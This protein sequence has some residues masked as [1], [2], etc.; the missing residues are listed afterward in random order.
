[1]SDKKLVTKRITWGD[2][3]LTLETGKVAHRADS[4]VLARYGDTI[5]L[6]T[7]CF[8]QPNPDISYFPLSVEFE[9]RLYAGGRISTS[10]FIKREG[11]PRESAIL[12]ARLID[13]SIRPLF[14]KDYAHEVQVIVTVLSV[15][16]E[17]KPDVLGAIAVSAALASSSIPWNGPVVLVRVG[18]TPAGFIANPTRSKQEQSDL[19]L[20]VS[21]VADGVNMV[22]GRAKEVP[23]N[24]IL[25]AIAFAQKEAQP[26]LALV[27]EF[28][29]E[30]NVSKHAY[31]VEE[32]AP[33]KEEAVRS[34][35]QKEL[36]V[37]LD[38]DPQCATDESWG[39]Q[40]LQ[41]L[42]NAFGESVAAKHLARIFADEFAQYVRGKTLVQKIRVDGRA[43]KEIRPIT[44]DVG[45]LPRTHGSALFRRGDTQALTVVTLGSPSLEQ[46]I[47]GMTGEETK[48]YM[49]HYNFPPYSTGEVRRVGAPG[50]REIGHGALAERA[51][52]PVIP[53]E[54]T[55]PYTIRVVSEIM[56]SA[57][58]TS[59]AAVCGSTLALMDAGVPITAPVAGVA[60]GLITRGDQ[61]VILS[62]IG[63]AEDA[64]GDMDLKIAGTNQ[65]IT[66]LQMDVK[67]AGVTHA[68]LAEAIAQAGEGRL[69]ILERMLAA[70][71]QSRQEVSKYAPK[72]AT[73]KID[74]A[75]I[76][77]IIGSGGR[78]IREIQA[79]TNT[80]IDVE[81]DGTVTVTAQA[82][83]QTTKALT[84]IE[85]LTHKV[86]AGETYEGVVRRILP[87]GAF[88]E[89]LPGREGMVHI[90]Q[91]APY[92]VE[93]VEDIVSIGQTVRVRVAEID[94]QGRVNLS[95]VFGT[96]ARPAPQERF[97]RRFEKDRRPRFRR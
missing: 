89:I 37:Q 62:D 93:K 54:G 8:R 88:I 13:R 18:K 49:H 27:R 94:H 32:L 80:V 55:F 14:P 71:P 15:D 12:S 77:D 61:Y 82:Q 11:R 56:S 92:R 47:E 66:A 45:L 16:Q 74:P 70:L 23:E 4:A 81:D 95:M 97:S 41:T 79:A 42:E 10:R 63:Y 40:A 68:L 90:S 72:I 19:D 39:P 76:G 46:L 67:T 64:N 6:A 28:A 26:V 84:W 51:L 65:G 33:E 91:L 96:E 38:K 50:R 35:I 31:T 2:T 59:M 1:M 17:N 73:V 9:E 69:V 78:T 58:S 44:V 22:E 24:Q 7:V 43:P 3:E 36:L 52:V 86:Q 57:G 85:G 53:S 30:V 29:K 48:R 34:V 25:E 20:M 87:F 75:S 60:M 21:V 5:V 83:E